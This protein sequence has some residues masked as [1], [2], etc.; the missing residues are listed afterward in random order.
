MPPIHRRTS[1]TIHTGVAP[2]AL[3][4]VGH[5]QYVSPRYLASN[6]RLRRPAELTETVRHLDAYGDPQGAAELADWLQNEYSSR[7]CG[8]VVG[9]FSHCYLGPPFIDHQLDMTT[10][11]LQHFTPSQ[12]VPPMFEPCRPYAR[13][14]AYAFIE[15]YA[16]GT[17]VPVRE[18]GEPVVITQQRNDHP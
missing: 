9:L 4:G 10:R 11:I 8:L 15:V 5:T 14:T 12:S 17:V 7:G 13:S 2:N 18:D 3:A 1:R 16:D 6:R